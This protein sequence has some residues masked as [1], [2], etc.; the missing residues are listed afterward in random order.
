MD[1]ATPGP[2]TCAPGLQEAVGLH[3]GSAAFEGT[4]TG[5]VL[6]VASG[7]HTRVFVLKQC[8][9]GEEGWTWNRQW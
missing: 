4:Q 3:D 5:F 1:A 7:Q 6:T 9:N 2:E 8:T